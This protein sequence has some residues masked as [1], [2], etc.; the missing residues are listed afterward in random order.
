MKKL[1]LFLLCATACFAQK[2]PITH[3]D[4][5]GMKRVSDVTVSPDGKSIVFLLTEPSYDPA[6]TSADLWL[7]PSDGSAPPRRLTYTK[8]PESSLAW[9]P[10]G[11]RIAFVTKREGDEAAQVYILPLTGPLSGGEARRVTDL[12]GGAANPQWRPDGNAIL[13]E[14]TYDPIADQR[15]QRKSSAR[16]YDAMPVR[17]WNVWL[18]EKRPH[19]FVQELADGA[20]PVDL[21]KGTKLAGS[22]GFAGF[23]EDTGGS[24][25]QS[26]WAPDGKSIVFAAFWNRN[27]MMSVESEAALYSISATGGEPQQITPKEQSY[28][29]PKFSL[30]GDALYAL[31]SRRATPGGRLY[32][33]TRLARFS[34]PPAG[35]TAGQPAILTGPWDRSVGSF[36][37][38][39]DG[40]TIYIAAEDDGFNQLFQLPAAGGSVERL[41]TVERGSYTG[42]Q[43]VDGGLIAL[44]QTAVEPVEIVRLNTSAASAAA[45][46]S[47]FHT[48]LTNFNADAV[49]Q[50]DAPA[51]IHFWFTAKDGRRIHNIMFLPPKFDASRHYPLLIFPHGGPNGM[52]TDAFSARWNGYLLASP[53]YVLLE[54][55]Y[56]GSTG[57][58][59]KFADDIERNVLRGPAKEILEAITEAIHRYPYIDEHRQAAAGASYGGYLMNWFNGHTNQ[60]KCIIDHA[61]AANNESQYGSNDG[62]IDRELRMGVP[63]WE[64]G[65]Q[66]I[67]Q[68]PFR[69]SGAY[70]TPTLITDGE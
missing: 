59:E 68:S 67:D 12:P 7:V 18:D 66:W 39:H 19:L 46:H 38:S 2:R 48:M 15:K 45:S 27:E 55:N 58:G 63:I 16:I 60:F 62:G 42:V 8:P 64:K 34:W 32:S 26:V 22:P 44:Y 57:F 37:L 35:Q 51:P 25:L 9:S 31:Q 30:Q 13:F 6:K 70:N 43:P 65:G 49:A 29:R 40:R 20:K 23:A 54:T 24:S 10:D 33:L 3:E 5:W 47:P 14:S 56:M 69:Y 21:L 36:S 41:F 53:G 50:I 1:V 4:I 17:F 61:G 11:S 28:F 52:S